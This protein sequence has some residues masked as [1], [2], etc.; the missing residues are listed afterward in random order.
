MIIEEW[1]NRSL[2]C[3]NL[4]LPSTEA[5]QIFFLSLWERV[6]VRAVIARMP[7]PHLNPLARWE[8]EEETEKLMKKKSLFLALSGFLFALSVRSGAADR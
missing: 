5:T 4:F 7:N 1:S 2:S 3:R 8:E 6:R